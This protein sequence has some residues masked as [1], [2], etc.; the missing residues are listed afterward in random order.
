MSAP[1]N[2]PLD[3]AEFDKARERFEAR[4][5]AFRAA[6]KQEKAVGFV[7]RALSVLAL[8]AGVSALWL[9]DALTVKTLVLSVLGAF[10]IKKIGDFRRNA[11]ADR[12]IKS[13]EEQWPK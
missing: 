3:L 2:K 5:A 6:T 4:A 1:T 7:W 12:T 13:I 10:V 8:V 9:L 11:W